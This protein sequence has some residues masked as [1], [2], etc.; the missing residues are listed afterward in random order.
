VDE[1]ERGVGG[2]SR[3]RR[4]G[5]IREKMTEDER[6]MLKVE[7]IKTE[8]SIYL[9]EGKEGLFLLTKKE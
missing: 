8:K 4:R 6:G 3:E 5:R 7:E 2:M 1:S 9:E